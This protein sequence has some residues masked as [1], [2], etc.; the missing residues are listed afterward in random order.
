MNLNETITAISTPPG[1]GGISVIR[2]VSDTIARLIISPA[3]LPVGIVTSFIGAP[4]F[5]WLIMRR[6]P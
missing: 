5:I 2:L 1:E 4:V 6:R 3:E